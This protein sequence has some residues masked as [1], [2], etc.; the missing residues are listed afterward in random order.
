MA[1]VLSLSCPLMTAS[2]HIMDSA[3]QCAI[4]VAGV[5]KI[6]HKMTHSL[7]KLRGT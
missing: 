4:E 5:A 2:T 1:S 3:F 7:A 6:K